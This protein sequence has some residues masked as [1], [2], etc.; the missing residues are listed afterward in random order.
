MKLLYK[1]AKYKTIL[2]IIFVLAL[3]LVLS[4][5]LAKGADPV[6]DPLGVNIIEDGDTT[7]GQ[8]A[9]GTS[10]L[11]VTAVKVINIALSLLGIIAVVVVLIGGFKWMTS[12]GD[13]TKVGDA[14]KWIFSGIIGLAIILSAWAIAKFAINNLGSATN[15]KDFT[16]V[17]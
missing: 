2:S 1:L 13:D 6:L 7:G 16:P 9:L 4:P 10:D 11:R 12:G 8:I 17:E 3:G 14:R 5:S 15:V